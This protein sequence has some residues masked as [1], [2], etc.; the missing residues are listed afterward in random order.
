MIKT[1]EDSEAEFKKMIDAMGKK[2]YLHRITDTKEVN[3]GK[4]RGQ[5]VI[6]KKTP[7]DWILT[8]DGRMFYA[9][10]KF[11]SNKTSFPLSALTEGQSVA[12]IRQRAAGGQYKIF[13]Y[14]SV[15]DTWYI[16]TETRV[17]ITEESG[18]KSIP[19]KELEY[20]KWKDFRYIPT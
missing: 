9:E 10:V 20:A 17:Q 14:H 2:A 1:W 4:M 19:W 7:A 15:T 11:C 8:Y 12:L 16:I 13:V 5:K 3:R 6:V 18:R